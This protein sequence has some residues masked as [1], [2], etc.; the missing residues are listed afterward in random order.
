MT[1]INDRL[2]DALLVCERRHRAHRGDQA[3]GRK[4]DIL[5]HRLQ[6]HVR[7]KRR[8]RIDHR[9][10]NVHR[11]RSARKVVEEV[12][13][14][15]VQQRIVVEH[16]GEIATLLLVRHRSMHKQIGDLNKRTGLD[17]FFD[18]DAAVTQ[19][20]ALAVDESDAAV[21]RSGVHEP[22]VNRDESGLLSELGDIKCFFAFGSGD[23]RKLYL[24]IADFQHDKFIFLHEPDSLQLRGCRYESRSQTPNRFFKRALNRIR[25][26]AQK[27]PFFKSG[28]NI[29]RHRA[30][31]ATSSANGRSASRKSTE[32]S[33]AVGTHFIS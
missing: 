28:Q 4:L 31:P 25:N 29:F 22:R 24:A 8:Q 3:R 18:R 21:A 15:L 20:S 13:H 12:T 14:I 32:P 16:F 30:A 26:L 5:L 9:R 23:N 2:A 17:Q 11:M 27:T 10:K 19:N 7:I 33:S 6:V 1:R